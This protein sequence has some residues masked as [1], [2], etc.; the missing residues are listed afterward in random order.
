MQTHT[1]G[2]QVL[3][4]PPTCV[5]LGASKI[6]LKGV[7]VTATAITANVKWCLSMIM[8]N[9][10]F[11][12]VGILVVSLILIT[13]GTG[14]SDAEKAT[15]EDTPSVPD[16]DNFFATPDEDEEV[17]HYTSEE[18]ERNRWISL[19][20]DGVETTETDEEVIRILEFARH[21]NETSHLSDSHNFTSDDPELYNVTSKEKRAIIGSDDRYGYPRY[22]LRGKTC[23]IGIMENGCT[24][25]LIGP[26]HAITAGHCVYDYAY[27]R[28]KQDLGI[29]LGRDCNTY[30]RFADWSRA[31]VLDV[32][33]DKRYNMAY[34][35][36]SSSFYS[37]CWLG[38][39]YRDP[40]PRTHV[41]SCGYHGDKR[42]G[43]YPCYYCDD[44]YAS[45]TIDNKR[46]KNTCDNYRAPGAP[47]VTS[48]VYAWGVHSHKS[49]SYNYAVRIT[50]ERFYTLCQ[51]KCNT[52]ARCSARC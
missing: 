22:G 12:L 49:S 47:M 35:L 31:W 24:A 37:S 26:R 5:T 13:G 32:N 34:I 46:M 20:R 19:S 8:S 40:M 11:F 25:F 33:G 18:I 50:K 7:R 27:R 17:Y 30:G 2:T 29:Y 44:C 15:F 28:W 4:L 16:D 38:Y 43:T 52:G 51:W 23:A 6:H 21:E 42:S 9:K 14:E 48:G 39:G 41:E 45:R 3:E 10:F 36:L 1:P